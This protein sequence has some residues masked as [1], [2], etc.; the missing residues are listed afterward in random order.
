MNDSTVKI[1]PPLP[2]NRDSL[3]G[4]IS[5]S[6]YTNIVLTVIA[7]CL[8]ALTYFVYMDTFSVDVDVIDMPYSIKVD[9]R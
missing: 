3:N 5:S 7:G 9:V 2:I 4:L 1:P 6:G 8:V